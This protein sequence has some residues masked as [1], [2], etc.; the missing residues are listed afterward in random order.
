MELVYG[1]LPGVEHYACMIDILGQA[2][3]LEEAVE[4]TEKMP[5]APTASI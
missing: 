1:V 4:L 5:M 3:L 2:N